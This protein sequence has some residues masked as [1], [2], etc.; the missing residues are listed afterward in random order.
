MIHLWNR[1]CMRV[2]CDF[3]ERVRS[4][5]LYMQAGGT[6]VVRARNCA[7]GEERE[8]SGSERKVEGSGESTRSDVRVWR[9]RGGSAR[10][11]DN[12]ARGCGAAV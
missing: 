10:G 6:V 7:D 2:E 5:Q 8:R 11:D 1:V 3:S 9:C 4:L 12:G